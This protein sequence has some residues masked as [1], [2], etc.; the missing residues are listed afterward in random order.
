MLVRLCINC[1][2]VDEEIWE[3]DV[4][5]VGFV[6]CVYYEWF[7]DDWWYYESVGCGVLFVVLD[8]LC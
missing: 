1:G 5:V 2:G 7:R 8:D 3:G 6:F 4:F